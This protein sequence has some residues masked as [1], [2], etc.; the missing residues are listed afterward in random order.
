MSTPDFL[1]A[2]I[3]DDVTLAYVDSWHG[4]AKEDMPER[5]TTVV[6]L[7]GVGFNSAVWTPLLPA[8]PSSIRFLAYNQRSYAQSSPAFDAKQPGGTDAT[9]TY[10]C[11]LMEFLRFAVEELGVQGVDEETHEGGIVLLAVSPPNSSTPT[12]FAEA[13][14]GWIG[15]YAPS[16]HADEVAEELLPASGLDALSPELRQLAWEPACVA[17]GFAWRLAEGADEVQR[18]AESALKPTGGVALPV[19]L[20]Y[21]TRTNG[22]CLDAAKTVEGW[23]GISDDAQE[24]GQEQ[25]KRK[26]AVRKVPGTNHFAFIHEPEAFA[27]AVVELVDELSL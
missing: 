5:Y 1:K 15:M 4:R 23:W 19:G 17:H 8:L 27:K 21:G 22:Y 9:A 14:A 6:G 10:L 2:R 11:D 16:A 26:T 24:T 7:H 25:A 18:L 3:S 20:I 13:F 12:E